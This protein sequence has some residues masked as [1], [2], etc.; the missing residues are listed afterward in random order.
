MSLNYRE[1]Y[2]IQDIRAKKLCFS[3]AMVLFTPVT[4]ISSV[5]SP[6]SHPIMLSDIG[7]DL[8]VEIEEYSRGYKEKLYAFESNNEIYIAIPSVYP[9]STSVL[10]LRM[11]IAPSAFLRLAHE[12]E[13]LFAFSPGIR[14]LPARMSKKLDAMRK[15][16][17]DF[18]ADV[19]RTFTELDRFSLAFDE[20]EIVNGYCE[21]IYRLS[22]LFAVPVKSVTVQNSKDGVPIKSNFALFTAFCTT[23]MMLV[24]NEATDRSLSVEQRFFGGSVVVDICFTPSTK[25]KVTNES[26]LWEYLAADKKMLFECYNDNGDFHIAFQPHYTDWAYLEMKQRKNADMIFSNDDNDNH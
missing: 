16:F 7:E 26:F 23:M 1:I 14:S 21:Q 13:D 6:R 11:D 4:V 15:G 9:T 20:D 10:I 2:S 17:F 24:R 3:A 18:C 22:S 19:E 25:T 8:L 5:N 12:R